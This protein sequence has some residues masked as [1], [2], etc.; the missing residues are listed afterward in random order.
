MKLL[1]DTAMDRGDEGYD[2]YYGWGILDISRAVCTLTGEEAA[3]A[4]PC[5]FLSGAAVYNSTDEDIDCTYFL[6]EYNK[7]GACTDVRLWRLTIPKHGIAEIEP[8]AGGRIYGQFV[9]K[10]LATCMPLTKMRK[11]S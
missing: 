11:S 7:H 3:S 6:A 4:M 5:R 10:S 8:P 1:S 2:E 9:F